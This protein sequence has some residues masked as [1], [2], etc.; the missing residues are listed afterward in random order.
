MNNSAIIFFNSQKEATKFYNGIPKRLS[1]TAIGHG[2]GIPDS[3]KRDYRLE[4]VA[5]TIAVY[6]GLPPKL[7]KLIKVYRSSSR[8]VRSSGRMFR[9]IGTIVIYEHYGSLLALAHE[10]AHFK[11]FPHGD[12]HLE[13]TI[14]GLE[15][16]NKDIRDYTLTILDGIL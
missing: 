13:A 9:L 11:V 3:W 8:I 15:I 4:T 14:K 7:S 5:Q 12:R 1:L 2:K 6:I 16:I 10:V